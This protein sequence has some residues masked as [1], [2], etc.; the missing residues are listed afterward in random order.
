MATALEMFDQVVIGR[1]T[2]SLEVT[3]LDSVPLR[4]LGYIL[5]DGIVYLCSIRCSMYIIFTLFL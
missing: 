3:L 4:N 1:T 5:E 2:C